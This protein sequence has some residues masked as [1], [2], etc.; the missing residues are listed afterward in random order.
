M[1]TEI[2]N[3]T[4]ELNSNIFVSFVP[5]NPAEQAMV[6]KAMNAPDMK[7]SDLINTEICIRDFIT[8]SITLHNDDGT[9]R[10][11]VRIG[12]IC[13]DGTTIVTSSNG[14]LRALKTMV[15]IFGKPSWS[16][17]IKVKVVQ[18]ERN[19]RR[20]FNLVPVFKG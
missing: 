5:S 13:V 16:D 14:I 11:G 4:D 6:Y 3:I 20:I 17:G 15:A 1:S 2:M 18:T 7:L 10:P 19:G 12:L 9:E 8:E